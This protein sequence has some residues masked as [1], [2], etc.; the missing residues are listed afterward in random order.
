MAAVIAPSTA[1]GKVPYPR[2]AHA[3][4]Q[5]GVPLPRGCA[6]PSTTP[7][8]HDA[9]QARRAP[10]ARWSSPSHLRRQ[11]ALGSTS[12]ETTLP[13]RQPFAIRLLPPPPRSVFWLKPTL[14]KAAASHS[15]DAEALVCCA[16]H[17]AAPFA[18]GGRGT[19]LHSL[20]EQPSLVLS[21]A[22]VACPC[23]FSARATLPAQRSSGIA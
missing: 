2:Q 23:P 11:T 1:R 22:L 14:L 6:A 13:S 20:F 15:R 10:T 9:T 5:D 19:L 3:G 7:A 16:S 21:P 18:D 8:V 12:S 4:K 17:K